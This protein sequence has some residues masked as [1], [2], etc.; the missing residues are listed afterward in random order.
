ML[1]P[2]DYYSKSMMGVHVDQH[3]LA[4]IV[5]TRLPKIHRYTNFFLSL[6]L[7]FYTAL[8]LTI[9]IQTDP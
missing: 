9:A 6:S 5:E 7:D 2:S 1:L 4:H 3:V 8:Y